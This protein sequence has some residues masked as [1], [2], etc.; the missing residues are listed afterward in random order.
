[1]TE[2]QLSIACSVYPAAELLLS[3]CV[4]H[5]PANATVLELGSGTGWF[6]IELSQ[7]RPDLKQVCMTD[8]ITRY[9]SRAL[10]SAPG[11]VAGAES[12]INETSGPAMCVAQLM[13]GEKLP[14][15]GSFDYVVGSDLVYSENCARLLCVTLRAILEAGQLAAEGEDGSTPRTEENA[16]NAAAERRT[17]LLRDSAGTGTTRARQCLI[18]HHCER[19]M[20]NIDPDLLFHLGSNSLRAVPLSPD[21]DS[22]YEYVHDTAP[23]RSYNVIFA[24]DFV[25]T[26][27]ETPVANPEAERVLRRALRHQDYMDA[28]MSPEEKIERAM[29]QAFATSLDSADAWESGIFGN[30]CSAI[31]AQ[32][33]DQ[34]GK[35][36]RKS[37][38]AQIE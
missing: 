9:T 17:A 37:A 28:L 6:G 19:F 16:C 4:D 30:V 18:A 29:T 33:E 21:P 14:D 31:Q 11:I 35:E 10:D 24:I 34:G 7:R 25:P 27:S 12:T 36:R 15:L 20:W 22:P 1:M 32:L 23:I 2:A 8:M 3:Y 5:L 13:W 38:I 26:A